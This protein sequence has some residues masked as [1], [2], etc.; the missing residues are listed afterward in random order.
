MQ[1]VLETF[2][3]TDKRKNAKTRDRTMGKPVRLHNSLLVCMRF[4][5]Y[6]LS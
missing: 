3:V 6:H 5:Y 2:G 1:P 4:Y